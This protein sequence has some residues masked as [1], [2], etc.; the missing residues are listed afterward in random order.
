M[1]R[2]P[3]AADGDDIRVYADGHRT[4]PLATLHTLRQQL[5][6]DREHPNLALA[7]FVAPA[8]APVEHDHV[9]A[10]AVTTGHGEPERAAAFERDNDDYN[11]I[12]FSALCDRLAEAFAERMHEHVRRELWG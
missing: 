8:G 12:L 1:G 9:G 2:W 6:R 11:R 3:A 5:V 10:F 4:A 7:D